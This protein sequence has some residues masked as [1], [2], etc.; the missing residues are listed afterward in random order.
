MANKKNK[1]ATTR[2]A[3]QS[4]AVIR[5]Q[6]GYYSDRIL[7]IMQQ[8]VPKGTFSRVGSQLGA[9]GGT[10]LGARAGMPAAGGAAGSQLGR[11][12]GSGV[13][14]LVGFGDYT[15]ASNTLFKEGMA[16]MPGEAVPSFGVMGAET[17]VRHR[18][19]IG[20]VLVPSTPSAFTNTSYTIN[21]GN[22]ATFPWLSA[23][24][25]NYQQ[26]KVN[27]MIFEFKTLSSDITSGGALG[28]VILATNYNVLDTAYADKIHMENAQFS[29]SAKPSCSQIHTIE[30]APNESATLIKYVR[31]NS[32]SSAV[33]QDARLY[34]MGKFQLA[35]AGL[36]GTTGAV[37]GELW[38]SYDISLYKPEIV[39]T[40]LSSR[41]VNGGTTSAAAMF[42]SAPTITGNALSDAATN[43]L[44]FNKVGEFLVTVSLTGTTMVAPTVGAGTAT[45]SLV[46][47]SPTGT[48]AIIAVY[49]VTTIADGQT[50]ILNAT[51]SATLSSSV[52]RVAAYKNSLA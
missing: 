47:N 40:V 15:V 9:I 24:A 32:S 10:A 52:T 20:D 28:S 50:L 14:R 49:L 48:T 29:V 43:T 51:G 13:S 18:E 39:D 3:N 11:F 17:R 27:G 7:P 31:D 33:S 38:V 26:Y 41:V 34:D 1:N 21:P 25:A 37:L 23:I 5:G 46:V 6:G 8:I 22:S 35:T 42:G 36:P 4:T 2:N 16:I 12:L 45:A 19:Y 44:T 30:C